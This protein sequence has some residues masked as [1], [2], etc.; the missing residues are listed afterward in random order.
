MKISSNTNNHKSFKGLYNN[1]YLLNG[2]RC[3]AKN[4][5]LFQ[6]GVSLAFSA[7]ARPLAIMSTPKTDKENKKIACAKSISSTLCGYFITMIA[8]KPIA[9]AIEHIDKNPSKY[10]NKLTMENFSEVGKHLTSSKKYSTATQ[11]FKL[12]VGLAIALPKSAL[13]CSLIIPVLNFIF[14]QKTL[15]DVQ[16]PKRA[17]SKNISFKGFYNQATKNIAKGIGFVLNTKPFQKFA[18]KLENT[19]YPQHMSSLTDI[20]LTYT[21]IRQTQ[22]KNSIKE[23]RKQPLI[24]NAIISTGLCLGGGYA[25]NSMTQKST[26]R[27]VEK[28][29]QVNKNL[30]DLDRCVEGIKIAKPALILA[31]IYYVFIPVISTFLADRTSVNPFFKKQSN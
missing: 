26:Q 5:A 2:L 19:N 14:P 21:F 6:A 24:H 30:P 16:K 13:T 20:L 25:I 1:K 3:A 18:T 17:K 12:G 8:S 9:K 27:F 22:K 28:F 31:G 15:P 4:G 10:L 11:L 29:K 23:N 7:I